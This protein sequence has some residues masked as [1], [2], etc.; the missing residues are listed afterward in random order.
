MKLMEKIMLIRN[1]EKPKQQNRAGSPIERVKTATV[2]RQRKRSKQETVIGLLQ[3]SEGATIVAI[4]KAT[5][6][7]HGFYGASSMERL[8]VETA[9]TE[10]VRRFKSIGR[11]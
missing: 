8:P 1:V 3:R 6:T 7:C 2:P 5:K 9:L 10:Q 11:R 4:M